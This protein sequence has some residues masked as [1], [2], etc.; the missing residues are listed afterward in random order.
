MMA[1]HAEENAAVMCTSLAN[2]L[3]RDVMT[4]DPVTFVSATTVG[5]L[6]NHDLQ[7]YRVGSFPLVAPDGQ[8]A[9][10][11]TMGRIRRVPTDSRS[12]TR[13]I[14]IARP[15]SDVPTSSPGETIVDLLLRM[16]ASSDGR[17]FVMDEADRLVGIVSP[18]DIA[19]HVQLAMLQSQR[20]SGRRG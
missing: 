18:S 20:R 10:F 4:K 11:T 14:D 9:G 13:L 2:V 8:L 3:V 1:A 12:S 17:A 7:H 19:R 6:I 16:Q 15:L 5:D